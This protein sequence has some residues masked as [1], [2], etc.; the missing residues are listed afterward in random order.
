M[1]EQS[2][3]ELVEK[4]LSLEFD[5]VFTEVPFLQRYIDIIG[6]DKCSRKTI[7]VE[8][9]VKNWQVALRQAR[10]CLLCSDEVYIAMPK[11]FVHRVDNRILQ[12]YGIGL[13]SVG[14]TVKTVLESGPPKYKHSYHS[15][16]LISLLDHMEST[17]NGV[18]LY[19]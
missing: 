18:N 8:A 10:V 2:I 3:V 9:K 7:A 11:D 14:G 19:E 6:Y 4:H 16:W 17:Q 12:E 1:L 13:M 15:D 5:S